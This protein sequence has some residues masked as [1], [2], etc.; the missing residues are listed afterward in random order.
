METRPCV[1]WPLGFLTTMRLNSNHPSMTH[2]VVCDYPK[3]SH[4]C[5]Y[6]LGFHIILRIIHGNGFIYFCT[7]NGEVWELVHIHIQLMV[8]IS[9]NQMGSW[10]CWTSIYYQHVNKDY[11][12]N[13]N[14]CSNGYHCFLENLTNKNLGFFCL[15]FVI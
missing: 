10:Q 13:I 11:V 7:W 8:E 5:S 3:C 6:K 15:N 2:L 4:K 12:P 9:Y 14:N 1:L